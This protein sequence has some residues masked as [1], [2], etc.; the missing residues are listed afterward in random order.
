MRLL[1]Q[2]EGLVADLES[3]DTEFGLH[4]IQT[5]QGSLHREF[6]RG[7]PFSTDGPS[8]SQAPHL[9]CKMGSIL[10]LFPMETRMSIQS[11]VQ[12]HAGHPG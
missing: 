3:I 7:T 6:L 11:H 4:F 9:I 12:P 5:P 10:P 1:C 8:R 2:I